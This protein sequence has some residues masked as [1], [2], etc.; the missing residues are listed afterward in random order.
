ML[1][2]L[3]LLVAAPTGVAQSIS[4]YSVEGRKVSQCCAFDVKSGYY[5]VKTVDCDWSEV[6]VTITKD[7]RI[8]ADH[9]F[10]IGGPPTEY[11]TP[12]PE[13]LR[14]ETN[15]G[16]AIGMTRAQLTQR[17]GTPTRTAVRGAHREFWCAL[18]R[19]VRM[20]SK[21][22]GAVWDNTYIFKNGRLIEIRLDYQAI[23]GCGEVDPFSFEGWPYSHF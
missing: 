6:S 13:P 14:L 1:Y 17:R 7:R 2:A 18:Y 23:P 12:K 5:L 22:E 19:K 8:V 11:S 15:L 3:L 10:V 20:T 16:E 9:G 21:S 4:G